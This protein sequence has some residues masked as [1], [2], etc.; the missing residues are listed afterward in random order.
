MTHKREIVLFPIAILM[1]FLVLFGAYSA[2]SAY[3]KTR[4][5]GWKDIGIVKQVEITDDWQR[6]FWIETLKHGLIVSKDG[7]NGNMTYPFF[8]GCASYSTSFHLNDTLGI[9]YRASCG[10]EMHR[11]YP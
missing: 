11:L 4:F 9:I 6:M 7:A 10:Y 5:R 3:E 2:Y 8:L 1:I